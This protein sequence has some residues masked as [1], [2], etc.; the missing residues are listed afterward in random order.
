MA[1]ADRIE[2]DQAPAAAP[3]TSPTPP[4]ESSGSELEVVVPPAPG[5]PLEAPGLGQTPATVPPPIEDAGLT[6]R[7]EAAAVPARVEEPSGP[8]APEERGGQVVPAE[9]PEVRRKLSAHLPRQPGTE[10]SLP[11]R[12]RPVP[13]QPP[14]APEPVAEVPLHTP[15]QAQSILSRLNRVQES[16]ADGSSEARPLSLAELL[17]WQPN[18]PTGG[19]AASPL[20]APVEARNGEVESGAPAVAEGEA[21]EQR[22]QTPAIPDSAGETAGPAQMALPRGPV[23]PQNPSSTVPGPAGLAAARPGPEAAVAPLPQSPDADQGAALPHPVR[24]DVAPK[25]SAENG[26]SL[27]APQAPLPGR[28]GTHTAGSVPAVP[29]GWSAGGPE[30]ARGEPLQRTSGFSPVVPGAPPQPRPLSGGLPLPPVQPSPTAAP[31]GF[32]PQTAGPGPRIAERLDGGPVTEAGG[33]ARPREVMGQ[34]APMPRPVARALADPTAR[35]PLPLEVR[36]RLAPLLGQDVPGVHVIQ[37]AHATEATAAAA[38][39][40]L[41]VG[42]TVL[43][44][45]GQD[46]ASPRGLGLLA[47][48]LTHVLRTRDPSFVPRVVQAEPQGRGRAAR[49]DEETLAERVEGQVRQHFAPPRPAPRPSGMAAPSPTSAAPP[50]VPP[51]RPAGGSWG[52]LPAPWEPMPYWEASAAPAPASPALGSPAFSPPAAPRPAPSGGPGVGPSAAP[53]AAGAPAVRAASVTRSV[54]PPS[55]PASA[56]AADSARTQGL[57]VGNDQQRASRAA[58]DLDRLAQQVYG[59]LKRRLSAEVRRDH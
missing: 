46:L 58:P 28:E 13:Y 36:S 43:L 29:P 40:A 54:D 12:P 1:Q 25:A 27:S 3:P 24:P 53:A 35:A 14:R 11:R 52:G 19:N 10:L 5:E 45:P 47:H 38:A 33:V 16:E 55:Q 18:P 37:N 56:P 8:Q 48:E 31:A 50:S 15:E 26:A 7:Q 21:T 59:L 9:D 39:D 22:G 57:P 4:P 17:A 49:L 41:A 32:P 51:P 20:E 30:Q 23:D 34:A 42:D 2:V 6:V 44:S